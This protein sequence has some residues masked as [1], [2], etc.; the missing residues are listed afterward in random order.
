MGVGSRASGGSAGDLDTDSPQ[1]RQEMVPHH[2]AFSCFGFSGAPLPPLPP[3]PHVPRPTTAPQPVTLLRLLVCV[4][5]LSF[6][7][8][9]NAS[10]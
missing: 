9:I 5:E 1:E 4:C 3:L 8:N 10:A 2:S 7:G 6:G